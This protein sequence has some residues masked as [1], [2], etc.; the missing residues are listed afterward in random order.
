MGGGGHFGLSRTESWYLLVDNQ[1]FVTIGGRTPAAIAELG[2]L[3]VYGLL[4]AG[5]EPGALPSRRKCA[6]C[7]RCKPKNSNNLLINDL[8]IN[9]LRYYIPIASPWTAAIHPC[10]YVF[11]RM[12]DVASIAFIVHLRAV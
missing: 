1:I 11:G 4:I 5:Q 8:T 6:I 7:G 2:A 9:A 10:T 3:D 12:V